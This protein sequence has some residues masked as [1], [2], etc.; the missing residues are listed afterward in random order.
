MAK[1]RK[2]WEIAIFGIVGFVVVPMILLF[3]ACAIGDK[4]LKQTHAEWDQK[5]ASLVERK[6]SVDEV[7]QV[8]LDAGE[9]PEEFEADEKSGRAHELVVRSERKPLWSIFLSSLNLHVKFDKNGFATSYDV[10]EAYGAL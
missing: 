9:E 8:F 5:L 1:K 4:D 6:A 10:I 7:R 2:W 3:G